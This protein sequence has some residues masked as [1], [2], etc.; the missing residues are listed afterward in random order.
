MRHARFRHRP[1]CNT[2]SS[3]AEEISM[4]A[5]RI[6]ADWGDPV[7]GNGILNR[8]AFL[9]GTLALGASGVGVAHAYAEPLTIEPWMQTP[10]AGFVG[11]GQPSRFESKVVR[12][13]PPSP[14]PA[15]QGV[16]PARTPMHLL[17]GTITPS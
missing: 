9:G 15:T 11:Y 3:S 12:F 16:G 5:K 8:R 2:S 10:G 17:E 1:L 14:N 13:I 4:V 6:N 7:A